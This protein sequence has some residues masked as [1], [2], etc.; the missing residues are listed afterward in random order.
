MFS[1]KIFKL[2]DHLE[3]LAQQDLPDLEANAEKPDQ[4]ELSDHRARW[5]NQDPLVCK[6]PLVK[7][8]RRDPRELRVTKV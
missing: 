4:P 8:A 5:A 7:T 3:Q 2:R 1:I 6:D